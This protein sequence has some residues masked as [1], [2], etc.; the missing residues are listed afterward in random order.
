MSLNTRLLKLERSPLRSVRAKC[1]ECG[2]PLP[3]NSPLPT[4]L[5][6]GSV[7]LD[8]PEWGEAESEGDDGRSDFCGTCGRQVVF[9]LKFDRVG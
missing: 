1:T 8:F 2:W 7:V 5:P 9:R 6:E 4:P 3:G